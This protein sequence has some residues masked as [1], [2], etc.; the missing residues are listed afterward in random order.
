[1][2]KLLFVLLAVMFFG[3][4]GMNAYA[5][6]VD[7]YNEV[8]S[9]SLMELSEQG[10]GDNFLREDAFPDELVQIR[11]FGASRFSILR[12]W[13]AQPE[14]WIAPAS[15]SQVTSEWNEWHTV[16]ALMR[17][18]GTFASV[19]DTPRSNSGRGTVSARS[20]YTVHPFV[21]ASGFYQ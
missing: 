11:P 3:F 21:V 5:Y 12:V 1:M 14:L 6:E 7:E 2:K 15:A 20:W 16:T 13:R 18:A 10:F 9:I 17:C 19:P 4:L 8:P